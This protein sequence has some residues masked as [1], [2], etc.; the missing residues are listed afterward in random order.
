MP[1]ITIKP[2]LDT[3]R[4]LA[5]RHL[6]KGSIDGL[7]SL[8]QTLEMDN[9][10]FADLLKPLLTTE[11]STDDSTTEPQRQRNNSTIEN[12]IRKIPTP[13]K[14]KPITTLNKS[15]N[16]R[17]LVRLIVSP[18]NFLGFGL[19]NTD[20]GDFDHDGTI[21]QLFASDL[22]PGDVITLNRTPHYGLNDLDYTKVDLEKRRR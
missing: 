3:F 21:G 1:N 19:E 12:I 5:R 10:A 7:A 13:P 22:K 11:K 4:I 18:T 17:Y 2:Y 20:T 16:T 6:E 9:K 8:K 15:E 14:H